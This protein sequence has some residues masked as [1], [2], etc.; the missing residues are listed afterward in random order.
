M[1][2][3]FSQDLMINCV[4]CVLEVNK[5]P[6]CKF[7]FVKCSFDTIN[8]ISNGIGSGKILPKV[9]LFEIKNFCS[10]KNFINILCINFSSILSILDEREI[11]L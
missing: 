10:G 8:K 9:K 2:Q 5:S 4:K 1:P 6:A 3:L 7:V 11:G